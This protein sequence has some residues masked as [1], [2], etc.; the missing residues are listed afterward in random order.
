MPYGVSTAA[1]ISCRAAGDSRATRS[2]M[3]AANVGGTVGSAWSAVAS[4]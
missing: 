2:K 4:S 1:S 3:V